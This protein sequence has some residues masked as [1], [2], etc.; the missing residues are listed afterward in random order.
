VPCVYVEG[1]RIVGLD[2]NDPIKVSYAGKVGT[3]PTGAE[4]PDLLKM[5]PSHG[6]DQTI[7]NGISRIGTMTGGQAARWIDE[8]MADVF[9]RRAV[10]FIDDNKAKPF[11][12]YFAT[13]DI[14]VPRAPHARFVGQTEMGA[15][16]DVIAQLDWSVGQVL[17][18]L[19]KLKLSN[20]TLVIFSSDNGPVVDDGYQDQAVAKLG[21][22]KSAGP[23]RGGKYSLFEGGTRVPFIASWPAKIKPGESDALLAQHDLFAS[24]AAL[25]GQVLADDAA[26]D[27]FNVLPALLGESKVGRDHLI[28]HANGTALRVGQWK[29]IPGGKGAKVLGN[30]N[31]ET[32]LDTGGQLFDLANDPGE[33]TNV[34]A[35]SGERVKEMSAKLEQLKMAGRSR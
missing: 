34:A 12:L 27:S 8:D 17:E 31:T 21:D 10:K 18:T 28:E 5:K 2:A 30:T 26:P 22:H 13:H 32:G 11:F 6:H 14:H 23:W 25:T 9:T 24:F 29:F 3:E 15:R 35:Q 16:G 1:R 4:R 19:E 33:K 7:I 20:D